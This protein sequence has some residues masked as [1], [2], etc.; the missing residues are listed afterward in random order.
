MGEGGASRRG[1]PLLVTAELPPDVFAWAES[2]RR[3]YY[4]PERNKISAHVTLFHGLPPSAEREI[5]ATLAS[6]AAHNLPPKAAIDGIMPLGHGT[7]LKISSPALIAI[8]EQ[9]AESFHGLLTQQDSHPLMPH[10]TVQNKVTRGEAK[11]LQN[12][13]RNTLEPRNF[14]F[15][16][17]ALH[18]Y[19]EGWWDFVQR[20]AFRGAKGS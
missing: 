1:A 20:W 18:I 8:H 2:L 13:L 6:A 11:A 10:I 4:P 7:A 5:R 19:R 16:G 9:L 17:L 12:R 14:V 3:M 15:Y